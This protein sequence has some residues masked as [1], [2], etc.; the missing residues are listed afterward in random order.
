M[1]DT[2]RAVKES[3]DK[4]AKKSG[5]LLSRARG[6]L[7]GLVGKEEQPTKKKPEAAPSG[8]DKT[9]T[10]SDPKKQKA[11]SAATELFG[12]IKKAAG[13]ARSKVREAAKGVKDG[14]QQKALE[15]STATVLAAVKGMGIDLSRLPPG[16][17]SQ[18]LTS[19]LLAH[20]AKERGLEPDAVIRILRQELMQNPDIA[21]GMKLADLLKR[22]SVG[23]GAAANQLLKE[24]VPP[25]IKQKMNA[26]FQLLGYGGFDAVV[27]T[28]QKL[29]GEPQYNKALQTAARL[30]LD[31][32]FA[33]ASRKTG[34]PVNIL[35]KVILKSDSAYYPAP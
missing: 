15:A 13:D 19:N 26:D 27:A 7:G 25:E 31:V 22:V 2:P 14:V 11:A 21:R 24:G 5:G 12:D 32:V 35:E 17:N 28:H 16:V 33:N 34:L 6:A 30:S 8:T 10:E 18:R 29:W 4:T 3:I 20:A 9:S 23:D 1:T